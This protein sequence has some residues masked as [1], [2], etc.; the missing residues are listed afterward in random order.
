VSLPLG[1][2]SLL[3]YALGWKVRIEK[4]MLRK[5][6]SPAEKNNPTME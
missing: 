1:N 5:L 3:T 6:S 4:T 2:T